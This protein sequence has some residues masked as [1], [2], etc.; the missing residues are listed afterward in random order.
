MKIVEKEGRKTFSCGESNMT[1]EATSKIGTG[2]CSTNA[3]HHISHPLQALRTDDIEVQ[4]IDHHTSSDQH[5]QHQ[6]KVMKIP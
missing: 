5:Q 4:V 1:G 6:H 2:G 3:T